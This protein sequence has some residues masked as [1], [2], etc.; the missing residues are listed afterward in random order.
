MAIFG[1]L[2]KASLSFLMNG[3]KSPGLGLHKN[4]GNTE[5]RGWRR[6]DD[7]E[8]WIEEVPS[9]WGTDHWF[10]YIYGVNGTEYERLK[11]N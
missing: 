2:E 9:E 10:S 8:L 4:D 3:M 7:S 11:V 6:S 1:F 5:D